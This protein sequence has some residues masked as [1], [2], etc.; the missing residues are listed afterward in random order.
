MG[1]FRRKR[2]WQDH[3]T[4]E[5][6][7]SEPSDAE[8]ARGVTQT[9]WGWDIAW[10]N[11]EQL[12]GTEALMVSFG[13]MERGASDYGGPRLVY[14]S[15]AG[16]PDGLGEPGKQ[17]WRTTEQAARTVAETVAQYL[18]RREGHDR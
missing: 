14:G 10:T 16:L 13:L 11:W 4:V 7:A 12:H 5:T 3:W 15:R 2:R 17:D 9:F 6:W 8:R 1:L 18:W